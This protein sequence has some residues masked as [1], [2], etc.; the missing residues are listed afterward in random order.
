M[1]HFLIIFPEHPGAAV[2]P[3]VA[4]LS[5]FICLWMKSSAIITNL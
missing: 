4:L 5:R 1:T 3:W 2:S